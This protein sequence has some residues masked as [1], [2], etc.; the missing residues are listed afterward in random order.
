MNSILN[1]GWTGKIALNE[2][3]P[4]RPTA[5]GKDLPPVRCT[6]DELW[7]STLE[8]FK[9]VI[10]DYRSEGSE[11]ITW[12]STQMGTI[13]SAISEYDEQ[14]LREH[15]KDGSAF[16]MFPLHVQDAV[17]DGDDASGVIIYDQKSDRPEFFVKIA[18]I[19]Y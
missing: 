8:N 6:Y 7:K 15:I 10:N 12:G 13:L 11:A 16:M 18:D 1:S 14:A 19:A 4:Y 3:H 5:E 9:D 17:L 2:E